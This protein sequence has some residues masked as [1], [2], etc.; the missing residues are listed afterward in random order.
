MSINAESKVESLLLVDD[1][2]MIRRLLNVRL[3]ELG[4]TIY[5]AT[6]TEQ[7]AVQ[8]REHLVSL[9]MMDIRMPGKSGEAYLPEILSEYPETAVIMCTAVSEASTAIECLKRGAC[10]YL[11]K[12]FN[13]DE[14]SMSVKSALEKRRL[15]RENRDHQNNLEHKVAA[16][17][18]V[19]KDSFL[20]SIEALAFALEA[21]DDYTIGHSQRVGEMAVVIAG[22]LGLSKEVQE[23][24][25]LAGL[26][27]DIGKIGINEIVLNKPGTLT[28][29][30]YGAVKQ[31]CQIGERILSPV[32]D[33]K[34][35]MQMVR[36]HHERY[37]GSGYPDGTQGVDIPIGAAILSVCDAFDAMT[38]KRPYRSSMKTDI[39]FEEIK[40]GRG[41]QF[42][43]QV[44]DAFLR[45]REYLAPPLPKNAGV[46]I[47]VGK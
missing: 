18:Q 2:A 37:D 13:F 26:I 40:L 4:Y 30:E 22:A 27:H 31:H 47:E 16:Q 33:D 46:E 35:L 23:K 12:P 39:A 6:D 32:M 7:A 45:S 38:S 36:S 20:N 11:T 1:E 24:V 41:K 44:V 15:I 10:D 9:V 34:E 29:A 19:I 3:S 42:N 25:R 17:A 5:E 14:V 43:P 21:K 8:L 28:A